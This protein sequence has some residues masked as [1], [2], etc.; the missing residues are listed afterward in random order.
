MASTPCL[1][2]RLQARDPARHLAA[3]GGSCGT[4]ESQLGAPHFP[5][6]AAAVREAA[7]DG[8][9]SAAKRGGWK[10]VRPSRE[11]AWQDD[12]DDSAGAVSAPYPRHIGTRNAWASG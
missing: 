4:E 9:A 3:N 1:L 10:A 12:P 11:Q 8:P 5:S 7:R 2:H 6:S